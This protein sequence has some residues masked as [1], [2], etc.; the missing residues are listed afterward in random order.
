MKGEIVHPSRLVPKVI[1]YIKLFL[2]R[3]RLQTSQESLEEIVNPVMRILS[4]KPSGFRCIFVLH[5]NIYAKR[6]VN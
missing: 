1:P 2:E 3:S 6:V 5:E 4:E